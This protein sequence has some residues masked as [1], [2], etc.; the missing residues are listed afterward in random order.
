M[1]LEQQEAAAVDQLVLNWCKTWNV[2]PAKVSKNFSVNPQGQLQ[3]DLHLDLAIP[4][5]SVN[6]RIVV[7]NSDE[8]RPLF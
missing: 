5:T 1:N 7:L 2:N 6:T 4:I 8:P 3:L